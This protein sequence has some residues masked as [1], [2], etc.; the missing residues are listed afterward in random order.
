MSME[1]ATS[2]D[3]TASWQFLNTTL[4]CSRLGAECSYVVREA[5]WVNCRVWHQGKRPAC[6]QSAM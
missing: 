1:L 3:V 2:V 5:V 6:R 4:K